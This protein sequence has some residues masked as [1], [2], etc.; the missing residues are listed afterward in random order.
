MFAGHAIC[1]LCDVGISF[2]KT[3]GMDDTNTCPE[4]H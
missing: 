2:L 1:L 3:E 4:D